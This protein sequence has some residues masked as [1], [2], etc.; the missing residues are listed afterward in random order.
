MG[1]LA[2]AAAFVVGMFVLDGAID[3]KVDELAAGFP[4]DLFIILAGVTF[5]FAIAKNNGTI[6]WLVHAACSRCAGGSP[7]PVDHVLGH[8]RC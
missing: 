2:I 3:E 6:D 7:H 1:A 4:G 5:L 8:R